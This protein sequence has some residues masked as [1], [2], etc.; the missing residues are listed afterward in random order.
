MSQEKVVRVN[1]VQLLLFIVSAIGFI[2]FVGGVFVGTGIDPQLNLRGRMSVYSI[3][4]LGLTL[5][6]ACRYAMLEMES[7]SR[8][9]RLC[10][11]VAALIAFFLFWHVSSGL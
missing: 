7:A 2:V 11:G 10:C 4:M 9:S 5:G 1:V 6:F 3:A 8:F